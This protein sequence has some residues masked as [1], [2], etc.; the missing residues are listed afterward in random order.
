MLDNNYT[1]GFSLS[2]WDYIQK[3]DGSFD[4]K[5]IYIDINSIATV[6]AG[7]SI[8]LGSGLQASDIV[9][10]ACEVND[11]GIPEKLEKAL[12]LPRTSESIV[13]GDYTVGYGANLAL[14]IQPK[15]LVFGDK[16]SYFECSTDDEYNDL[17]EN[18]Y[19]FGE[20]VFLEVFSQELFLDYTDFEN[21]LKQRNRV[22]YETNL[23]VDPAT[24][25]FTGFNKEIKLPVKV[26]EVTLIDNP[27][28]N[29]Y[30]EEISLKQS[31]LTSKKE[32]TELEYSY[33]ALNF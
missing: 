26:N 6:Y 8:D 15:C 22:V 3:D 30:E 2:K 10:T 9:P 20:G 1:I 32:V 19:N 12:C 13:F 16:G 33:D 11:A 5:Q 18:L 4:L 24:G 17:V 31:F 28:Q 25:K 23:K 29:P 21:P 27:W 14:V 7:Q